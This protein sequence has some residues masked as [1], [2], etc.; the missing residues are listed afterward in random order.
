MTISGAAAEQSL[1]VHRLSRTARATTAIAAATR[2]GLKGVLRFVFMDR[3]QDAYS[4]ACLIANDAADPREP[5]NGASLRPDA[6]L[7]RHVGSVRLHGEAL[8]EEDGFT[9]VRMHN[10]KKFVYS[11][12]DG[13][14]RHAEECV[15]LRRPVQ[16][17]VLKVPIPDPHRWVARGEAGSRCGN[18]HF[19]FDALPFGNVGGDT[20]DSIGLAGVVP[21]RKFDR[22]I[23]V[24]AVRMRRIFFVFDRGVPLQY[25]HIVGAKRI[26]EIAG[27]NFMIGMI[28]NLLR[29]DVEELFEPTIGEQVP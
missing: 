2:G 4:L 24:Q 28:D 1:M 10:P 19:V 12:T 23:G 18:A 20:A 25:G 29:R 8:D 13:T 16:L 11:A 22:D 6:M 21:E 14:G 26:G 5:V 7:K 9:I 17:T 27:E 3:S 15:N